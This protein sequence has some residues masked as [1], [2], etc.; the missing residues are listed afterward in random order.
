MEISLTLTHKNLNQYETVVVRK[1]YQVLFLSNDLKTLDLYSCLIV[2]ARNRLTAAPK[3]GTDLEIGFSVSIDSPSPLT[4]EKEERLSEFRK[5]SSPWTLMW[6]TPSIIPIKN[7]QPGTG[8]Y[9][10]ALSEVGATSREREVAK[11]FGFEQLFEGD[12]LDKDRANRFFEACAKQEAIILRGDVDEQA[13]IDEAIKN[14]CICVPAVESDNDGRENHLS[15]TIS[16][17]AETANDL[18]G[19]DVIS[20]RRFTFSNI[21]WKSNLSGRK[22]AI[23]WAFPNRGTPQD[24]ADEST[25][26]RFDDVKLYVVMPPDW[27]PIEEGATI[28]SSIVGPADI[29]PQRKN[30]LD[31]MVRDDRLYFDE[32]KSRFGIGDCT[33]FRLRGKPLDLINDVPYREIKFE[34][35]LQLTPFTR[36]EFFAGLMIPVIVAF[37]LDGHRLTHFREYSEVIAARCIELKSSCTN[38]AFPY[39]GLFEPTVA[40]LLAGLT[41]T[42]M[43]VCEVWGTRR[44]SRGVSTVSQ[45]TTLREAIA[46]RA[47]Y[48]FYL[49]YFFAGLWFWWGL[50]RSDTRVPP[51]PGFTF[52]WIES[53][54]GYIWSGL[55]LIGI[56]YIAY[57]C[58]SVKRYHIWGIRL[59]FSEAIRELFGTRIRILIWILVLAL[60]GLLIS[61]RTAGPLF[62]YTSSMIREEATV[63]V[64]K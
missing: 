25:I 59:R 50:V 29:V 54:L 20:W 40:W 43:L 27:M 19:V 8:I 22:L 39:W 57:V 49:A 3:T 58:F 64:K 62:G 53:N 13:V 26:F 47:R 46:L 9:S 23:K 15:C 44:V 33:V 60:L 11:R 42:V 30:P 12:T 48:C 32:W 7:S 24:R 36:S 2:G 45:K 63:Y 14:F 10:R 31:K 34:T 28:D 21:D 61:H 37:G 18:P 5:N 4:I 51:N 41:L 17:P 35:E 1:L 56:M 52:G 38:V 16:R 55:V 6:G